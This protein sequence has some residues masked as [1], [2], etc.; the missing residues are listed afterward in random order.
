M[1]TVVLDTVC[2]QAGLD[3]NGARL[4]KFTNNA[5][6]ELARQPIVV[7]IAGSQTV[8]DRAPKVINV[9]KWLARN[10]M[11]AVRLL[12][13]IHQPVQAHGHLATLWQRVSPTGR[14][15]NGAD[16]G[17]ILHRYHRLLPPDVPLPPWRPLAPIRQRIA[18]TDVLSESDLAFLE[19]KCGELEEAVADLAYDLPQGPIHGDSFL[20]NLIP[21]RT[22]PVI[23]DFDSA[24]EGPREWDLTPIAV[25]NL[26]FAY[27]GRIQQ[28]LAD[29]YGFDITRWPGFPAFRQLREL[30]LVT[31]V[32]PVLRDNP[33]LYEQWRH[34]LKTFQSG[35]I[36]AVWTPYR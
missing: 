7:R 20:G 3:P 10:G 32:L 26:R 30:Q 16:L 18:E 2:R 14:A 9:A 11:P 12:D 19:T 21:G 6:L 25:G 29:T 15:P 34:R 17:R 27:P 24:A 4:I 13:G 23:C 22:G 1:L 33:S 36:E 35:D 28:E 8:R 31:S 5:V